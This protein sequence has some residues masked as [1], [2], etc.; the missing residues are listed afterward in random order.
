M[1]NILCEM[2]FPTSIISIYT[3]DKDQPYYFLK[4]A[5]NLHHLNMSEVPPSLSAKVSWFYELY[6]ILKRIIS[7]GSITIGT[8]HDINA[9]IAFLRNKNRRILGCEHIQKEMLPLSSKLI[10]RMTYPLLHSLVLLSESAREKYISYNSNTTVIPNA[11]PF[12]VSNIK[13]VFEKKII[14]VGR[15]DMNKGY[16]RAIPIFCYLKEKYPEWEV[17]IYGD[18]VEKN[19]I[20]KLIESNDLTNVK[21]HLPVKNIAEKYS[22]S[23]IMLMTSYSEAMPMVI[24]EANSCGLPVVAYECEGTRELI[25]D[26]ETGFLIKSDDI[27]S[28]C[29]LLSLLIENAEKMKIFSDA[30]LEYAKQFSKQNISSLWGKLL[31]S[32]F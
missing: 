30:S 1:A 27:K 23:S 6:R 5:V 21:I 10:M 22:E 25:K 19:N 2:G 14:M 31:E 13:N 28:F 3:N 12:E 16:G 7:A 32:V 17:N 18:G 8:G 26:G 24:L 9:I 15:I 4:P 11:L 29:D 20:E